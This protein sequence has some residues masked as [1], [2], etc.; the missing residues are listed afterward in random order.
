MHSITQKQVTQSNMTEP[1]LSPIVEQPNVHGVV[2]Q[3]VLFDKVV[4]FEERTATEE[5]VREVP[6]LKDV[7]APKVV[8]T[9]TELVFPEFVK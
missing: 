2:P 1:H 6:V 3:A 4:K 5:I 7:S 8:S 9:K